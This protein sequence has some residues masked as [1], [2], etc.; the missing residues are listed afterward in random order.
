M[1]TSVPDGL[2]FSDLKQYAQEAKERDAKTEPKVPTYGDKEYTSEQ[3]I[4]F[5]RKL[6]NDASAEINDPMVHKIMALEIISNMAQWHS[7][8]G[9]TIFPDDSDCGLAWIRDA[10]KFQAAIDILCSINLGEDDW[11]TPLP[12]SDD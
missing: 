9:A 1:S 11:I 7:S 12:S 3:L 6:L 8:T 5:A 2:S 4:A 10:G